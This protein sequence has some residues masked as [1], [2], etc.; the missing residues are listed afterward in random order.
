[1]CRSKKLQVGEWV[2]VK[3]KDEILRTL[4]KQGQ[5]QGIPF[6]PEM[7]QYCGQS[8]QIYKRA[9]KT[10]DTVNP[11]R[12]LRVTDAV[13][14][15][16]RCTGEAHGGCQAA[17][18]LFWKTAWLKRLKTPG[19]SQDKIWSHP[20]SDKAHEGSADIC[21]ESDVEASTIRQGPL[22][23]NDSYYVCQ[24]TQV[25]HFGRTLPWWDFRQYLEDFTSGNVTAGELLRGAIFASYSMLVEAGIGVGP[26]LRKLYDLF[27]STWGGLPYPHKSGAIPHGSS[28]PISILNLQ[29]GEIVRVKTHR[30]ILATLD[31]SSKN[32]GLMFGGEMMPHCGGT[33]RVR[34]RLHKF[35]DEKTGKL[36]TTKQATVILDGVWCRSRYSW[37]RMFCPRAIYGWWRENWLERVPNTESQYSE[38]KKEVFQP[39]RRKVKFP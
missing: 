18:L 37:C 5:L 12:S 29:P 1:M 20:V 6:M 35:I 19:E 28:T 38:D 3:S 9:H 27:Q 10:C 22:S 39:E 15:D 2:Q 8:F 14:L 7:F 13:H 36:L 16:L 34:A 11:V 24:A 21:S 17:C 30:E 32:R 26:A 31:T 33:Y 4:D 23:A 25:P